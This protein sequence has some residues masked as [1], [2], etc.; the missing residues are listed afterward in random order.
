MGRVTAARMMVRSGTIGAVDQRGID[1]IRGLI[2]DAARALFAEQGYERTT[3]KEIARRAGVL[4]PL[5][6]R[7][8]GSKAGVFDAAVVAPFTELIEAYVQSWERE[9]SGADT[10][11]RISTF[12]EGLFELARQNRALLLTAIAHREAGVSP[13]PD[14]LDRIATALHGIDTVGAVPRDYPAVDPPS[15]VAVLG[16]MLFGLALLDPMLFA[17]GTRRPSR[18]RILTEM[19]EILLRGITREDPLEGRGPR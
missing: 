2:L 14:V 12:L 1:H 5:L 17:R 13:E 3:T 19:T 10:E 7:N 11:E 6:F 16:S 9:S 4:E 15:A 8:F 18:S